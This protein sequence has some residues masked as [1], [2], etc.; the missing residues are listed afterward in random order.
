MVYPATGIAVSN[1]SSWGTS[2]TAPVA[3]NALATLD[4]TQTL[5]NK[6]VTPRMNS[7]TTTTSPWAWSS[8]SY[9]I[10]AFTAL[11]TALTINA[12][13]GTPT[14]GQKAIFRFLDN[15]TG[16][17]LTF[18]GGT[19]KG[20]RPV[21]VTLTVSGSD[22]TYTTTANKTVYFGCIYNFAVSR[23]DIIALSLEA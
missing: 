17:I 1:G 22:F 2:L 20:F 12:D 18:T 4:D 21:G 19:A 3:P 8:D 5:T 23:W 6:R 14:D 15:G 13:G 9:D 7:Q 16:R 11:D 10:Q